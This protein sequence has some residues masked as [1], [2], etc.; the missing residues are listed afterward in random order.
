MVNLWIATTAAEADGMELP[1]RV[2]CIL[3]VGDTVE[4]RFRLKGAT[5]HSTDGSQYRSSTAPREVAVATGSGTGCDDV[6]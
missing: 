1:E 2:R 4:Q 3:A 5:T 6:R